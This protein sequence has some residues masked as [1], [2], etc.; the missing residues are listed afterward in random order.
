MPL[1][2]LTQYSL[3]PCSDTGTCPPGPCWI[4][5]WGWYWAV[6]PFLAHGLTFVPWLRVFNPVAQQVKGCQCSGAAH[7]S[8]A[9]P[10]GRK[11]SGNLLGYKV[12]LLPVLGKRSLSLGVLLGWVLSPSGW[13]RYFSGISGPFSPSLP[14]P[15]LS[16]AVPSSHL[17]LPRQGS[18][19]SSTIMTS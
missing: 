11:S 10:Q 15:R 12:S 1:G 19:P 2:L 4:V 18:C 9:R 14:P 3:A 17:C 7:L 13:F 16:E 5:L 6:A 8:L